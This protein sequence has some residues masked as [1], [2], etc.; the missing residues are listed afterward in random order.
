MQHIAAAGLVRSNT[1]MPLADGSGFIATVQ[2]G[3]GGPRA[4]RLLT[5]LEGDIIGP[6][7][8]VRGVQGPACG[9]N[10]A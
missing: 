6:R 3:G 1:P 10:H 7:R 9:A 5:F 4:V 8:L 2:L